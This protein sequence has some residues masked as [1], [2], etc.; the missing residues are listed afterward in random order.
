MA[1]GST[2]VSRHADANGLQR[3]SPS[4]ARSEEAQEGAIDCGAMEAR[5]VDPH[6]QDLPSVR[7]GWMSAFGKP[8]RPM[9]RHQRA[10]T[11]RTAGGSACDGA[12]AVRVPANVLRFR[13]AINTS[14]PAPEAILFYKSGSACEGIHISNAIDFGRTWG[15]FCVDQ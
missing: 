6:E 5:A 15:V 9:R 10:I 1:A 11:T 8:E 2:S 12:G 7:R 13:P 14:G 4:L 3:I